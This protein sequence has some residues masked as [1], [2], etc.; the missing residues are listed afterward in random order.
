MPERTDQGEVTGLTRLA[1]G[2]AQVGHHKFGD[3]IFHPAMSVPLISLGL[4]LTIH[5]AEGGTH[6]HLTISVSPSSIVILGN[7]F[8]GSQLLKTR[9]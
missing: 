5:K 3:V 9:P 2:P 4:F 1:E 8:Q 6:P 7:K